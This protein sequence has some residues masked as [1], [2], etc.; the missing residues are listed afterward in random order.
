VNQRKRD[1]IVK[2]AIVSWGYA[3]SEMGIVTEIT[4][5]GFTIGIRNGKLTPDGDPD[6][7]ER[8]ITFDELEENEN[9]QVFK[10]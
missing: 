1:R 9:M 6:H 7:D 4:E 8:T 2:D 5:T 3:V 10:P